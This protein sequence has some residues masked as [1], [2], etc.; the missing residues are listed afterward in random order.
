M[1][2]TLCLVPQFQHLCP[3]PWKLKVVSGMCPGAVG[4]A[5]CRNL[6][7]P[8][9]LQPWSCFPPSPFTFKAA[10]RSAFPNPWMWMEAQS[11]EQAVDQAPAV[12]PPSLSLCPVPG[13]HPGSKHQQDKSSQEKPW[14]FSCWIPAAS[15]A[16]R[17][18]AAP[19]DGIEPFISMDCPWC[20]GHGFTPTQPFP[21]S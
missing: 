18:L 3:R 5:C 9:L 6:R 7:H 12:L 4:C 19:E 20:C 16:F 2:H 15:Q 17:D 8:A 1:D 10:S 11:L 21:S 13:T 14:N